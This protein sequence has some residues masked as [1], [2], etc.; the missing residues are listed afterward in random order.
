MGEKKRKFDSIEEE[1]TFLREEVVRLRKRN[2][3]LNVTNKEFRQKIQI[4]LDGKKEGEELLNKKIEL[5]EEE[6]KGEKNKSLWT[7]IFG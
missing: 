7:R 4:L 2:N 3:A 1:V 5:L 6:L